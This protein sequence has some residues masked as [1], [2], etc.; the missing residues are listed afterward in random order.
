MPPKP[1][2][3]GLKHVWL[4][5]VLHAKP[6]ARMGDPHETAKNCLK[7]GARRRKNDAPRRKSSA[8]KQKRRKRG[9]RRRR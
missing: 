7:C 5:Y 8:G 3:T 1:Q 4:S 6:M 2:K 9:S